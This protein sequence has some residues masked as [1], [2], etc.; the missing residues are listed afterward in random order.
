MPL[1]KPASAMTIADQ[2][3]DQGAGEAVKKE[4]AFRVAQRVMTC[5]PRD[6]EEF[7]QLGTVKYVGAVEGQKGTWIG[8]D[9][10]SGEGRH[11]GSLEGVRY[12]QA[13][14]PSSAS[15]VRSHLLSTGCTLIEAINSRYKGSTDP[16]EEGV[17]D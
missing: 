11:D 4:M 16:S 6:K 7:P 9:W 17:D 15:F 14:L 10:D 3:E 13:R 12:F 5:C 1:L 2:M 8:V